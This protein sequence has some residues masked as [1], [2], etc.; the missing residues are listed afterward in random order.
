MDNTLPKRRITI[1][2]LLLMTYFSLIACKNSQLNIYGGCIALVGSIFVEKLFSSDRLKI[3]FPTSCKCLYYF[4]VFCFFSRFWAWELYFVQNL[5][6]QLIAVFLLIT[7]AV[8]YF[9]KIKNPSIVIAAVACVGVVL[10]CYVIYVE[11]G[12]I[13]F[14]NSATSGTDRIGGEVTNVNNIGM[15]GAL[16]TVILAY[17][18]IVQKKRRYIPLAIIPFMAAAASGSRKS[19]L[20]LGIGIILI[21]LLSQKDRQGVV[22][23]LK[24]MVWLCVGFVAFKM[25]MS[26]E[27][28]GTVKMRWDGLIASLTGESLN[29][30][31]SADTRM[32]MIKRGWSQ[33]LKDPLIGIGLGNSKE[34]YWRNYG[35]YMYLHN[36]YIEHLVNGGIVGFSLYYGNLVYIFVR[37]VKLMK[38]NKDPE[39]IMS[40]IILVL[41][42][43]MNTACVTY[44]DS[45]QTALY[46]ILWITTIEVKKIEFS[47]LEQESLTENKNADGGGMKCVP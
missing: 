46:F 34:F 41:F 29:A 16:S 31:T 18:G 22:K 26:L 44:Y 32:L 3:T 15:A 30:D 45:L 13:A 4:T 10:S 38:I 6:K 23:F 37:H 35:S 17:Y 40:F 9:I 11:G 21:V 25:I 5:S 36:D 39:I 27:I 33:F 47:Q 2:G 24:I 20:L 7:I 43:I 14:Y 19:L 8:G 1:T 28:M 42:F 12:L